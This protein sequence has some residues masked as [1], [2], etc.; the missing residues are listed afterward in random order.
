MDVVIMDDEFY[1]QLLPGATYQR[2]RRL[3]QAGYG[4]AGW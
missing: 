1:E 4:V 2:R 3:M